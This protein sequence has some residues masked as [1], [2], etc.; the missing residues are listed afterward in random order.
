[1]SERREDPRPKMR[2]AV[3]SAAHDLRRTRAGQY[4]D[5]LVAVASTYEENLALSFGTTMESY[6]RLMLDVAAGE[7]ADVRGERELAP[8]RSLP[9]GDQ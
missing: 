3:Q 2:A 6:W 9:R 4:E 8:V 1:M 5:A 7:L